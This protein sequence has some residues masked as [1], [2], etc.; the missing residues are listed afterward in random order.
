L[1]TTVELWDE[2]CAHL[3]GIPWQGDELVNY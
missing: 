1:E 3:I 2:G